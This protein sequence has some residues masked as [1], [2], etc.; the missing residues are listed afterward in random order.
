MGRRVEKKY[1][2]DYRV[3]FVDKFSMHHSSKNHRE[4]TE[5]NPEQA[6]RGQAFALSAIEMDKVFLVV[7]RPRGVKPVKK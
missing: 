5:E 2:L 4:T 6:A 7:L 3:V 1:N